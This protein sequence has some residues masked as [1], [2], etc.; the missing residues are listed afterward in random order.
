MKKRLAV[1][2]ILAMLLWQAGEADTAETHA[3]ETDDVETG[4][5]G[6][7]YSIPDVPDLKIPD[8]EAP[9]IPK[10]SEDDETGIKVPKIPKVELPDVDF[11]HVTA[12]N[13]V[14]P[15]EDDAAEEGVYKREG[16]VEE[17]EPTTDV[18]AQTGAVSPEEALDALGEEVYRTTYEALLSGEVVEKG[19]RGDTAKGVQQTLVAFGQDIAV[20]GNVGPRTIAA[21]NAVQEAFGL[22]L[23][24]SVDAAGYGEMLRCLLT[25]MTE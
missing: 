6:A 1:A 5:S 17:Q 4:A 20:D 25:A 13:P 7:R 21:L 15:E 16:S 24:E 23:T 12:P 11:P 2:L 14:A 22:E 10:A 3:G 8:I 19:S 9:D 18:A